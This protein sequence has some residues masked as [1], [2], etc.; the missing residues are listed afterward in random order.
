MTLDEIDELVFKDPARAAELAELALAAAPARDKVRALGILGTALQRSGRLDD[1]QEVLD[2]ACATPA[3][4][5]EHANALSRTAYLC[6][7]RW[8]WVRG[9]ALADQAAAIHGEAGLP[10]PPDRGLAAVL[11]GRGMIRHYAY[12]YGAPSAIADLIAAGMD[13]RKALALILDPREAPRCHLAASHNLGVLALETGSGLTLARES[14]WQARAHLRRLDIPRYSAAGASL[15][16]VSAVV[17]AELFGFCGA[18]ERQL[19]RARRNFHALGQT[20]DAIRCG[21]DLGLYYLEPDMPRWEDLERLS[22]DYFRLFP[23]EQPPQVLGALALWRQSILE[24]V[25]PERELG[26]ILTTVRGVRAHDPRHAHGA[27][28]RPDPQ[29][30]A[31]HMPL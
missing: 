22:V 28:R 30:L 31:R 11:L 7:D 9:I 16:W 18:Q 5:F 17:D 13:Y 24:R 8:E 2:R 21:L 19:K 25:M 6:L 15:E 4:P 1:A 3:T 23:E 12:W 27:W 20:M 26:W 14:F 29:L 10:G